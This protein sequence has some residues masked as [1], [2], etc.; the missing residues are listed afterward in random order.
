MLLRQGRVRKQ[1]PSWHHLHHPH[2]LDRKLSLNQEIEEE[3][4]QPDQR[5]IAAGL[6]LTLPPEASPPLPEE[7]EVDGSS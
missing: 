6:L 3:C 7:A 2:F 1:G 5:L 4:D